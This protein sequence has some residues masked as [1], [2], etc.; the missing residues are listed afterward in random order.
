MKKLEETLLTSNEN[1]S[2]LELRLLAKSIIN[3]KAN[4][5]IKC[6]LDGGSWTDQFLSIMMVTERGL[7][8]NDDVTNKIKSINFIDQVVQFVLDKPFDNYSPNLAY[9]VR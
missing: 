3:N 8:L 5:R 7:V 4:I 6:L 2:P 1:I 9:I